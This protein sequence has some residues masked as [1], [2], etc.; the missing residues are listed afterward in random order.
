MARH[1]NKHIQEALEYAEDRGW[2]VKKSAARAHAW[3]T[4]FCDFGHKTCWMAIYSTPK[5]PENHAREI[6]RK[7]DRCPGATED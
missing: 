5:G 4:I 6:R 1:H 7:V 2:T 3:G